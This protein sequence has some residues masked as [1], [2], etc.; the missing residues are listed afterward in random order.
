MD[1]IGQAH[2]YGGRNLGDGHF[3]GLI[4]VRHAFR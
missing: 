2:F 4:V 3:R 1:V